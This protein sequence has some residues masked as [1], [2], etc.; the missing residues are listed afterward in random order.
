MLLGSGDAANSPSAVPVSNASGKKYYISGEV[1]KAG[2]FPLT[3][4][5]TIYE[6]LIDAGGL[7]DFAKSTRIYVL[8]GNAKLPFNYKE[9]SRGKNLQQNILLQDGDVVVVP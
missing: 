9:V 1:R 4:P 2:A 5:K 7:A 3:G 8:R 6:A